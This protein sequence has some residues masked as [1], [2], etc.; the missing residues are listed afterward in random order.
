MDIEPDDTVNNGLSDNELA[1]WLALNQTSGIGPLGFQRLRQH[2]SNINEVFSANSGELRQLGLRANTLRDLQKP[3]WPEVEKQQNW[4]SKPGNALLTSAC[5]DYP[6]LL[7]ELA[8]PPPVLYV[9]GSVE[10]LHHPQIA[11]VGSRKPSPGGE[12]NAKQL[13]LE[14]SQRGLTITSGLAYGIDAAAHSGALM[15]KRPT[16]AVLGSGLNNVYPRRH[17][18]LARRICENGTLVS[19]WPPET[20]PLAHHFPRRNRIISGLSLATL[21][22]E[23]SENSGSLITARLALEQGREVMAVPG[24]IQNPMAA[25]SNRLIQDGATL[26]SSAEDV[27]NNLNGFLQL[28]PPPRNHSPSSTVTKLDKLQY[29]VL[30]SIDYDPT[31]IDNI[32]V[33]SGLTIEQVSSIL[34]ALELLGQVSSAPGGMYYRLRN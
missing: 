14:L 4:A 8:D 24:A 27:L 13:S 30:Y 21:I 18:D 7:L 25:G 29:K 23:A 9:S 32:V 20:A 6:K 31:S 1:H 22:I 26:I 28:S 33:Q 19:E 5:P 2:F 16:I 11:I 34:L 17:Q 12:Q 3:D 10:S 15:A